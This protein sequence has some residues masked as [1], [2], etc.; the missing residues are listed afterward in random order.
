MPGCNGRRRLQHYIQ[1]LGKGICY[2]VV[3]HFFLESSCNLYLSVTGRENQNFGSVISKS[4]LSRCSFLM[5][6]R[7]SARISG[8]SAATLWSSWISEA[9]YRAAVRLLLPPVSSRPFSR[10]SVGFVKFPVQVIVMFLLCILARKGRSDRDSVETITSQLSVGITLGK[11][12]DASQIAESRQ[13]IV[14]RQTGYRSPL[15]P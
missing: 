12:S 1:W 8:C 4:L 11:V 15:L 10:Q 9:D 3:H 7:S 13:Q 6:A 5:A 14:K 2:V